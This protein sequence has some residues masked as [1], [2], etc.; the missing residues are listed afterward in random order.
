MTRNPTQ[1][2]FDDFCTEESG[3]SDLSNDKSQHE[4]SS[5]N[6]NETLDEDPD[7]QSLDKQSCN[8]SEHSRLYVCKL[9]KKI[10]NRTNLLSEIQDE[11]LIDELSNKPYWTGDTL[12]DE[13]FEEIDGSVISRSSGETYLS[14]IRKLVR[15]LHDVDEDILTTEVG[16]I[17][18]LCRKMA[19]QDLSKTM[20]ERQIAITNHVY[21]YIEL[22][23]D[24][25]TN[26][27]YPA[28]QNISARDFQTPDPV[29]V[30]PLSISELHK[31]ASSFD[32]FRN[33]L[34]FLV[35]CVTGARNESLRIIKL[36]DVNLDDNEI[37]LEN[38][39]YNGTYTIPIS[40]QMALELERWINVI[41]EPCVDESDNPYLFPSTKSGKIEHKNSLN[42][43][44]KEA[45]EEAGIQEV[46]K[47]RE[48]TPA[49]RRNGVE[50]D[51][52]EY[53]RVTVHLLRH[54]FSYLLE[55]AGLNTE[56]RRDALDHDSI[57]TTEKYYSYDRS[58]YETL[59]REMVHGE[60]PENDDEESSE[61]SIIGFGT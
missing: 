21:D 30:E 45:A 4:T 48:P 7:K 11:G 46:V 57:R 15:H 19:H 44:I 52:I 43:I 9:N 26:M 40:N 35:G 25:E 61:S 6:S 39:K 5:A 8:C 13:A 41:R 24:Y 3:Y 29:E 17:I 1:Q 18:G 37:K 50:C 54:T 56:A 10:K 28:L 33:R 36:E 55:E 16:N 38:T 47:E 59:I 12:V 31:L 42:R 53:H 58:D 2:T 14:N 34:F 20:F 51:E 23:T 49:E 32:S 27:N 60:D 22:E